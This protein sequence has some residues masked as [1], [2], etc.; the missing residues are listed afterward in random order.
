M[1]RGMKRGT[2]VGQVPWLVYNIVRDTRFCRM[3]CIQAC[4]DDFV[5][6]GRPR[7]NSSLFADLCC[8]A[9]CTYT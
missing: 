7:V 1:K 2:I 5:L 8:C 6:I 3:Q 9:A 4:V